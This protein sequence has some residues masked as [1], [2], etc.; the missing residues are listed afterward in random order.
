MALTILSAAKGGGKTSFLLQWVEHLQRQGR[1]VGGIAQPAVFEHGLRIGYDLLDLHSG[2]SR[3]LA[4]LTDRPSATVGIFRFDE[5]ALEEGRK[6]IV[7]ATSGEFDVVALDEIGPL[8][9]RGGGWAQAIDL[10]LERS[11]DSHDLI[12]VVRPKL[13]HQLP[14]RFPSPLWESARCVTP[15]WP[16]VTQL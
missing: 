12:V 6:S 7:K 9:F 15:P 16:P 8:E 11:I 13:L 2:N 14:E 1:F 5:Q 3:P 10:A 4:R